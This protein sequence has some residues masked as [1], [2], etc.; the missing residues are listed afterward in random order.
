MPEAFVT[1]FFLLPAA[2]GML[3]F[4]EPCTIG[5]HLVFLRSIEG[6]SRA[7]KLMSTLIFTAARTLIAAVFGALAALLGLVLIGAQKGFWLGF[8]FVYLALGLAYLS[9]RA[10]LLKHRIALSPRSWSKMKNPAIL[11]LAFG[12]NIPACAA[13]ILFALIGVAASTGSVL[14]G[15]STMTVFALALS[16]PLIVIAVVPKLAAGLDTI[17]AKLG[18]MHRLLGLIFIALGLWAIWFGLYV[19]PADWAGI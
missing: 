14:A 4:I 10:G 8:G 17:S 13:P 18:Q 2:L 6:R 15:L 12:L 19:N 11:G 7:K 9:G 16:S 5:A 3:G 1:T